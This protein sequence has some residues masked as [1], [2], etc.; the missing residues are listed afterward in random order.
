MAKKIITLNLEGL[1]GNAFVLLS[2]FRRQAQR[3]GWAEDEI[4][5]VLTEAKNGDYWH[6]VATLLA[7]C[8]SEA[9][10]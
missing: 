10:E 6:L 7:H 5:S 4:K 3:E 1:D 2:A 9:A 8:E